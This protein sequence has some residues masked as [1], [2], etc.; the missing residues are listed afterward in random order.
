MQLG[1]IGLGTMG[2]PMA[3]NLMRGGNAMAVWSR[4]AES[5]APLVA[6]GATG[7][8]TPAALGALS[9]VV[10][11]MVTSTEDVR[12][13]VLGED[14][15][16]AGLRSGSL[17][18]DMSTVDPGVTREIASSLADIGVDM[19]DAPVSGGPK[20]AQDAPLAIMRLSVPSAA[21]STGA[22]T[23]VVEPM[24]SCP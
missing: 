16:R 15:L 22:L 5:A 19:L 23:L 1:F 8:E 17:V 9:D 24:P 11:T 18:I 3:L 20:G 2:R 12:G 7:V 6:E 14:G 4:R 21:T 13:V 10:F